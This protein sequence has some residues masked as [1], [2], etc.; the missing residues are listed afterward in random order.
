M[1]FAARYAANC[2]H[3]YGRITPG[4]DV[5]YDED[6]LVHDDCQAGFEEFDATAKVC[7]SCHLTL[8]CGCEDS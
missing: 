4:D 6:R 2:G 8:P 7:P 5:R 3:C 1:T